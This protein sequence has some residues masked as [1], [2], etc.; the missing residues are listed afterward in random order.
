MT[1]QLRPYQAE[2]VDAFHQRVADGHLSNAGVA[3]TGLGKSTILMR[4]VA[5]HVAVTPDPRALVLCHRNELVIQLKATLA[6]VAPDIPVGIVAGQTH[7]PDY[8]VTIAMTPTLGGARGARRRD[9]LAQWGLPTMVGYDE[10][11]HAPARGNLAILDWAR[12]GGPGEREGGREPVIPL[13]GVTATLGRADRYGL[14]D[15]ITEDDIPYN[16]DIGY[17]VANGYLVRPRGRVVVAERLDL[18]G[19]A[20]SKGDYQERKLGEL[21][22]QSAASIV[23]DWIAHGE[24]RQTVGFV[25]TKEA[26]TALR[27]EFVA[28]GITCEIVTGQTTA[29]ERGDV[30]AGTGIYGRLAT[31]ATRVMLGLMVPTE[32]WDCPP[33][34]CVLM[35][36]PTLLWTLYAQMVGRGL[37]PV[38]ETLAA[39]L[40]WRVPA[41]GKVDCLVLDVVGTS[42]VQKLI[43]TPDIYPTASYDRSAL[44]PAEPA[45]TG[46]AP[47]RRGPRMLIGPAVY[48]DV[49]LLLAADT[50]GAW[51]ATQAGHPFLVSGDRFAVIMAEHDGGGATSYRVVTM[52]RRGRFEPT[53]LGNG[54]GLAAAQERAQR[55]AIS[56]GQ[57]ARAGAQWRTSSQRPSWRDLRRA[58]ALGIDDADT[59]TGREL[60]ELV[61]VVEI[62][63]RVDPFGPGAAAGRAS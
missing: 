30:Y 8:P 15:L 47:Q 28:R 4:S 2:A 56:R 54:L 10:F 6:E 32:G 50:G 41:G 3:A 57:S 9:H 31:G 22:A 39:K 20:K 36:R 55:W 12:A 52:N 44:G 33:V 42:R 62:S 51:L 35:G 18:S 46:S 24:D 26:A 34:S 60:S 58:G 1:R 38:D 61:D 16:L 40:G 59:Y 17:G 13:H 37:R 5:D 49:E 11:H 14:G 63:Q 19:V 48:E 23:A 43:T 21:I 7:Q 27:D 29:A 25:P 53:T 45:G